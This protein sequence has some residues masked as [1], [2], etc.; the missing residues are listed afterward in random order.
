MAKK[1]EY[2]L[3]KKLAYTSAPTAIA[4]NSKDSTEDLISVQEDSLVLLQE[5]LG[6]A[7]SPR[8]Q[9]HESIWLYRFV[10]TYKPNNEQPQFKFKH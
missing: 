6:L 10:K 2:G 1:C 7:F 8:F 4:I 5:Q 3:R 9:I